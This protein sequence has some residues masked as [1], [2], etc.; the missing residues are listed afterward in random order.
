MT[1]KPYL[2]LTYINTAKGTVVHVY[3]RGNKQI[4]AGKPREI[5]LGEILIGREVK[6]QENISV[7]Q[8]A[9]VMFIASN[10]KIAQRI[11]DTRERINFYVSAEDYQRLLDAYQKAKTLGIDFNPA[12]RMYNVMLQEIEVVEK[13]QLMLRKRVNDRVVFAELQKLGDDGFKIFS[14]I[15]KKRYG[16]NPLKTNQHS[17]SL[18]QKGAGSPT[19]WEFAVALETLVECGRN[20]FRIGLHFKE[21]LKLWF[22]GN[23]SEFALEQLVEEFTEIFNP[24][25]PEEVVNLMTQWYIEYQQQQAKFSKKRGGDETTII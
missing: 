10:L 18:Y 8:E 6:L 17:I 20:I 5:K 21:I 9:E 3:D 23:K 12:E 24:E 19:A 13:N 25:K 4:V 22:D 7:V 15:A 16:K 2:R 1:E 11:S 14:N